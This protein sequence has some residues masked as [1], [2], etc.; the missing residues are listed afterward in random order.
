MFSTDAVSSS[1]NGNLVCPFA[2][3]ATT[4]AHTTWLGEFVAKTVEED[5]TRL[6]ALP[7]I[8][9]GTAEGPT[10]IR[11]PHSQLIM[12]K[13][14]LTLLIAQLNLPT[15]P[16]AVAAL[17]TYLS[18]LSDSS[19][20]GAWTIRT[21]DLGQYMRLDASALRALNLM[22]SGNVSLTLQRLQYFMIHTIPWKEF[23]S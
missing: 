16:S 14:N 8:G 3:I 12:L 20:H 19:N 13:I 10:V 9:A 1:L 6:L 7:T 23:R 22:D 4:T 2:L 17:I 15:A 5:L 18:L 21:H 11:R